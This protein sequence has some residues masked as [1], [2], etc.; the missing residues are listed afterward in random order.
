VKAKREELFV[1]GLMKASG[2]VGGLEVGSNFTG[3]LSLFLVGGWRPGT[4][5]AL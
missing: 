5:W 4:E 2:F 3:G 1:G